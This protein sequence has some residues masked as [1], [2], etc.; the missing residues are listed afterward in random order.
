MTTQT[1]FLRAM[2]GAIMGAFS[3]IGMADTGTYTAQG[4]SPVSVQCMVNRGTQFQGFEAQGRSDDVFVTMLR[5]EIGNTDPPRGSVIEVQGVLYKIDTVVNR[6][7][8][9]VEVKVIR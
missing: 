8:S 2:D 4:G 3:A 5:S 9:I 1:E 6:D 7:E